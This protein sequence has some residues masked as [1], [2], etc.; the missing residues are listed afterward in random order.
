MSKKVIVK[1]TIESIVSDR[2]AQEYLDNPLVA[3]EGI[4]EE[5]EDHFAG[6]VSEIDVQ[7]LDVDEGPSEDVNVRFKRLSDTSVIPVKAH[8]TDAGF[9]LFADED[10]EIPYGQ[11]VVVPTNIA[12]ALPEGYV[13]DIRPRSGLTSKTDLRVQYGTVDANYRGN[14]GII[15]ENNSKP[16][17]EIDPDSDGWVTPIDDVYAIQTYSLSIR[18][19]DKIAQMVVLPL[20][21]VVLEEVDE[22][23]ETD[24]G[25]GGFGSTGTN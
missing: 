8:A 18:K 21:K 14:I 24:R 9:D 10:V 5:Y 11:T 15:V 3:R 7:I 23:D 17:F 16:E 6:N 22:L 2:N 13:A 4:R 20:P 19:G 25:E 1:T 12:I